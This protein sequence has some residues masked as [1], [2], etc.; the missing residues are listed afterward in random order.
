MKRRICVITGSRADYGILVP[1]MRAIQTSKTLKLYIIATCM[2]LMKEFGYTVREIEHGEFHVNEKV[3]ISYKEDS[4]QAMAFSI[5]K[6]VS[7]LSRSF[8]KLKPCIVVVLG[9]RGEMLAAAIAANYMNI[10]V[11]HIHGGEVSGH[12]DGLV[13]HAITKLSHIHFTA[14]EGARKRILKLGEEPWR[15]FNV[16]AP[17]LDCIIN[18]P[19][20]TRNYLFER[21][22][23]DH[24][25][26]FGLLV[27]HPV[28][29]ESGSAAQQIRT[30]LGIIKKLRL[31]TVI[32]YPNADA[33]GRSMIQAI[34]EC[35]GE[36]F[37][38]IF[39]SIPH[40][41]YLGLLKY[42]SVIIGN[43]SSG[44]IESPFF[45]LPVVNIGIRQLGRERSTNVLDVS[46]N[47][48]AIEKAIKKTLFDTTFKKKLKACKNPYGDGK[49]NQRI[50]K[51]LSTIALTNKLLVKHMTY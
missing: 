24:N 47:K 50:I 26:P 37:I 28:S 35:K 45:K 3:D 38:K 11:A 32:V 23:I 43:S 4:G 27:Q 10:S 34:N 14:T 44:I 15:V 19:L 8:K 5:G 7:A 22:A 9:D 30:V 18:E 16:G 29:T 36:P 41:D 6:A 49:A 46:Y 42:A 21:Y 25:Q 31:Q 20:P 48:N 51:V 2:H 40:T 13:R 33:G 17:S 12:V 39:K 1:V